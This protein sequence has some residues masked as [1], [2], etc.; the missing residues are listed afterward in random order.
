VITLRLEVVSGDPID[1]VLAA[2]RCVLWRRGPAVRIA[3]DDTEVARVRRELALRGTRTTVDPASVPMPPPLIR[4]VGT[5]LAPVRLQ[6]VE[7]DLIEL[8][9]VSLAAA[10]A[11][12]LRRPVR[13]WPL[14][15]RKLR[16]RALL[17]GTDA[18]FEVRRTAWCTRATLRAGRGS[19]RPALFDGAAR[20]RAQL[21]SASEHRLTAWIAG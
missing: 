15:R 16:C 3:V 20:S 8:Q 19:L 9:P 2:S 21:R 13:F 10:T 14:G 11:R 18:L 1:L 5:G 4:A 7:L 12:S 6:D 17:R